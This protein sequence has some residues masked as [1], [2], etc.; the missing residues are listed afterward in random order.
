M[1]KESKI[2]KRTIAT[3]MCVMMTVSFGAISVSATSKNLSTVSFADN[4]SAS[5]TSVTLPDKT[6]NV[7]SAVSIKNTSNTSVKEK[8]T[9]ELRRSRWYGSDLIAS[10]NATKSTAKKGTVNV[11]IKTTGTAPLNTNGYFCNC[12]AS[13][14]N[15]SHSTTFKTTLSY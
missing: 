1:F 14:T 10:G 9:V 5:T 15:K 3:L 6:I 12:I 4:G 11:S 2:F 13:N 8:V 7:N